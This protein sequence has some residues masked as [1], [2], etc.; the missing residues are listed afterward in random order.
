MKERKPSN[1]AENIREI[2]S[3]G[4]TVQQSPDGWYRAGQ[5]GFYTEWKDNLTAVAECVKLLK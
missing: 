2:E 1:D 4:W 3:R 5:G